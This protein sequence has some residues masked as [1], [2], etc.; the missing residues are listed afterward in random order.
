NPR[1]QALRLEDVRERGRDEDLEAGLLQRPRRVLARRAAAEVAPREQDLRPGVGRVVQLEALVL[2]PV[3]EEAFC[4]AGARDA[5]QELL[6][7][8]LVRV[9]VGPVEHGDATGRP[10]E[11]LHPASSSRTS[12]KR[13]SI[14]AAAA[15]AGLTRCVRPPRPCR[16]S[17]FR[18]EVEAHRSPGASMSGFI[19][20]HIE[21]P[22]SRHSKP[23]CVKMRSSPSASAC[24]FTVAEPGTTIARTVGWTRR[25]AA[26]LAA[27]RR[28]S[29]R[30]FVHEPMKTRSMRTC[31]IGVPG[32]S[33]MYSSALSTVGRSLGSN[34]DGCGTCP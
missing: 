29:I 11:R 26:T 23:A 19:P 13:P 27:T 32:S 14:A 2:A 25:P 5:L 7:D 18:F 12:T 30:E 6:R 9:D 3:E 21:Q 34:S 20:R 22:A 4:E 28:S 15:I 17:K 1:L 10:A 31:S 16:P 33:A 24:R 8:D